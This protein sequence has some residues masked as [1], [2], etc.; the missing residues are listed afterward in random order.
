MSED[1][2]DR[3]EFLKAIVVTAAAAGA[4]GVGAAFLAQGQNPAP[5]RL[6][7]SP[8]TGGPAGPAMPPAGAGAP[9]GSETVGRLI[10]VQADNVRLKAELD[11]ALRRL[12]ALQAAS[13]DSGTTIRSL[14]LELNDATVRLGI[15]S[16]LVALYEQLESI[17]LTDLVDDGLGAVS[18]AVD[19]L[20]DDLPALEDG[21]ALGRRALAEFEGQ[22][23]ALLF[24]RTWL[25]A[26]INRLAGFYD[27]V[28]ARLQEAVANVGEFLQMLGDWFG[29]L[30]RWVPFSRGERARIVIDALT[31][32]LA[33]TPGLIQGA[34]T[35]LSE[36]LDQWLQPAQPGSPIPLQARLL[37]PLREQA[38][39]PAQSLLQRARSAE[40]TFKSTLDEP[41]RG[42]LSERQT[43]RDLISAYR[44]EH[45]IDRLDAS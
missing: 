43:I 3:R 10:Q 44:Q 4:T 37:H 2:I 45:L 14:Q 33:E 12:D 15:L 22:L 5:A 41:V 39:A 36:P 13:G 38:L 32:L 20:V 40:Q 30:L 11:A 26:Q 31:N 28:I 8:A 6:A 34:R 35:H 19:A 7:V 21:L 27:G 25:E 17:D 9:A 23:P 18:G 29:D 24:G 1:S 16:G 42:A